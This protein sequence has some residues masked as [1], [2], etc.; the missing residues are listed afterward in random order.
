M[1]KGDYWSLAIGL[2]GVVVGVVTLAYP[3]IPKI[4]GLPIIIILAL[5][6]VWLV[7]MG[8]R[9]KPQKQAE[10]SKGLFVID[11]EDYD[12]K[13]ERILSVNTT[14]YAMPSRNLE[15]V[16]LKIMG[17]LRDSDWQPNSISNHIINASHSFR[18]NIPNS[19][20]DGKYTVHLVAYSSGEEFE[21][22]PFEINIPK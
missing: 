7:I 6:C 8:F 4:I 5:A 1:S 10:T 17:R 13:P 15:S 22:A 19:V 11:T 9:V 14:L 2:G 3:I 16:K 20:K 12:F 21:F 18:F